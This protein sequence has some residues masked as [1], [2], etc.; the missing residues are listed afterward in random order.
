MSNLA[1]GKTPLTERN[2]FIAGLNLEKIKKQ[3]FGK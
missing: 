2:L 1:E 3:G